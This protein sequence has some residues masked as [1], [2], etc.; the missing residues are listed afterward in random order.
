MEK[1]TNDL[2]KCISLSDELMSVLPPR[3]QWDAVTLNSMIR[4]MFAKQRQCGT[5]YCRA[6]I[7]AEIVQ[8]YN[9]IYSIGSLLNAHLEFHDSVDVCK[10]EAM[11][12]RL[13]PSGNQCRNCSI[14]Q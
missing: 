8:L 14:I 4:L 12:H 10:T 3:D 7:N 1:E 9:D 6:E 2:K 13:L 11:W 5:D